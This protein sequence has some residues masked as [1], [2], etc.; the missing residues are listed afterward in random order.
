MSDV[1]FAV[2]EAVF[3]KLSGDAAMQALIGSPARLYDHAPAEAVFPFLTLGATDAEAADD[4]NGYGALQIM[5]LHAWSRYR[6]RKE[7]QAILDAAYALLHHGDLTVSGHVCASCRWRDS[8]I[9]LEDDGL[10]YHGV[11]SYRILTLAE[12]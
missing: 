2:Q 12:G 6:G 7:T 3:T 10:T 8:A 11:A 4:K 9:G 1:L 5:T